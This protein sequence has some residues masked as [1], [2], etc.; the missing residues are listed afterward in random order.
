MSVSNN[1]AAD[2]TT[3]N[4]AFISRTKDSDTTGVVGLKNTSDPTSGA[5][6]TNAQKAINDNATAVANIL[7]VIPSL[8]TKVEVTTHTDD[9]TGVHGIADT[10]ALV[11]LTGAQ[12]LTNKDYDGGTA[13]NSRRLTVP[14]STKALLDALTRKEAT[15]VYAT[16]Q[17][18][19]Y[20]DNGATLKAVGAGAGSGSGGVNYIEQDNSDF[21]NGIGAWQTDNGAGTG[22]ASTVLTLSSETTSVLRGT[23]SLRIAKSAASASGHY[24]YI[25]STTIDP[26]DRGKVLWGSL[27]GDFSHA[28]YASGDLTIE[29]IDGVLLSSIPAYVEGGTS[30]AFNSGKGKYI[31]RVVTTATTSQVHLR[32]KGNS[33]SA[34]AYNVFI[35][36]VKLGPQE[37]VIGAGVSD[38]QS[39]PMVITGSVTN[40]TKASNATA[41]SAYW[42]IVGDTMEI[43]YFYRNPASPS[44]AA[45][46]SG[47]YGFNLPSGYSIDT[48][49]INVASSGGLNTVGSASGYIGSGS[50]NVTGSV[51]IQTAT[52]LNI[53][54]GDNAS[55]DLTVGSTFLPLTNAHVYYSFSARVPIANRSSNTVLSNSRVEYAFNSSTTT[56]SDA[57]S[58]GYGSGGANIQAFAPAAAG[59]ITKRVRFQSAI[60]PTDKLTLQFSS[61]GTVWFDHSDTPFTFMFSDDG[62][63]GYGAWISPVNSTDVDVVF[64]YR[65]LVGT[66]WSAYSAWRWRVVKCANPLAVETAPKEHKTSSSTLINWPIAVNTWGD[67]TS[68][69][70][71][72]GEWD[73]C[74]QAEFYSNTGGTTTTVVG[75]G[76]TTNSGATGAGLSKGDNYL[77]ATKRTAFDSRDPVAITPY[78][79]NVTAPTTYYLK[80]YAESSITNLQVAYR[81]S[82]RRIS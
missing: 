30:G 36:D 9:T 60:Q 56:S 65:A 38:W 68:F 75:L 59:T 4:N 43:Q 77:T 81:L 1:Q 58:F 82:A 73:L 13:A 3:F 50:V 78:K 46:G 33:T 39:F 67:L 41:D 54:L 53:V 16:D 51:V 32:I 76:I 57:T 69:Q 22:T 11:T 37:Y 63:T 52:V 5:A 79:V 19:L 2:A 18:K 55:G 64:Q 70:L 45:A 28:S 10:A 49:K 25:A 23:K 47:T 24:A 80:G 66:T 12:V 7:Q 14:K 72:P 34:L 8:A 6:I 15:L 31:F 62:T 61:N 48:S 74:C 40:P 44:G 71:P 26:A 29:A 17:G 21:E 20:Y 27:E 42:R 35:D